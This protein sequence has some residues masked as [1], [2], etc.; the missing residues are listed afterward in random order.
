MWQ[1]WLET[2]HKINTTSTIAENYTVG[3]SVLRVWRA[4][5]RNQLTLP[6]SYDVTRADQAYA[7]LA[8]T[9]CVASE[10]ILHV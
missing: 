9:V 4:L 2:S 1:L 8:T 7:I 3:N 10:Q 6:L 5:H